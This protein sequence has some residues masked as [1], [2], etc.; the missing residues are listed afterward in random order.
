[1][2]LITLIFVIFVSVCVCV[3]ECVCVCVH[4]RA[5]MPSVTQSLFDTPG[6]IDR[7]APLFM[8]FPRE[9]YWSFEW[10]ILLIAHL[11]QLDYKLYINIAF[12]SI[13]LGYVPLA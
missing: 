13:V 9:E 2:F 5:H 8:G 3:C 1:M 6:T 7:K 11:P 12:V 4:A 10:F